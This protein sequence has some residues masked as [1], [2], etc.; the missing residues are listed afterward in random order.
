MVA[1]THFVCPFSSWS[2]G[3]V[4]NC[5]HNCNFFDVE[6]QNEQVAEASF[7]VTGVKAEGGF[8]RPIPERFFEWGTNTVDW[9]CTNGFEFKLSPDCR[10]VHVRFVSHLF[11]PYTEHRKRFPGG[12]GDHDEFGYKKPK[13]ESQKTRYTVTSRHLKMEGGRVLTAL[14]F[15]EY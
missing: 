15:D 12:C 7:K 4:Y 6:G 5:V 10:L 2:E 9:H 14:E 8:H 11:I 13:P 1:A 3:F